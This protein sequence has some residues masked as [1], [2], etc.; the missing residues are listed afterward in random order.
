MCARSQ[1]TVTATVGMPSIPKPIELTMKLNFDDF[2]LQLRLDGLHATGCPV[3]SGAACAAAKLVVNDGAGR[4]EA[5]R[6]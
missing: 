5:G 3:H 6:Y 1:E 4:N 2:G